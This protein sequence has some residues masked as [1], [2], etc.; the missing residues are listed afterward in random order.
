MEIQKAKTK[1]LLIQLADYIPDLYR[2]HRQFLNYLMFL[3][4]NEWELALDSL[5]ELADETGHLFPN[6]FWLV[7]ATTANKIG[8][9][10]RADYCKKQIKNN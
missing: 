2:N 5:I 6:E 3:E 10:D 7:L 9:A 8:L 4:N 1:Q